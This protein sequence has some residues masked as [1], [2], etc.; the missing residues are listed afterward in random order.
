MVRSSTVT[1]PC[2]VAVGGIQVTSG[3]TLTACSSPIS[4]A[5]AAAD[6][7]ASV[8][9]PTPSGPCLSPVT[10]G[11][12]STFSPGTYCSGNQAH[13]I[14]AAATISAGRLLHRGR[15]FAISGSATATGTGVTFSIR[16]AILGVIDR[17]S[18][19]DLHSAHERH[20]FRHCIF[21]RPG[22]E[23]EAATTLLPAEAL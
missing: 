16:V 10:S 17:Q 5:A 6:P 4:G 21:W 11:N 13:R 20:L 23:P 14:A 1:M 9:Q 7:Y 22:R 19:C 2:L 3:L 18:E 15:K 8:P 12:T